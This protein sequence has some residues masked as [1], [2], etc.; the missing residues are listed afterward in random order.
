MWFL[1][2]WSTATLINLFSSLIK[3]TSLEGS[4]M[5]VL[6]LQVQSF[7]F[8]LWVFCSLKK[9]NSSFPCLK[10]LVLILLDFSKSVSFYYMVII[11][12]LCSTISWPRIIQIFS[13]TSRS[14]AYFIGF[15]WPFLIFAI[16][17]I[18]GFYLTRN[19]YNIV[20]IWPLEL[21]QHY[22]SRI[23]C[24]NQQ[25]WPMHDSMNVS[26]TK[27]DVWDFWSWCM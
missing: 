4:Q 2:K 10:N 14:K 26:H 27:F 3:T 21:S 25:L 24:K 18:S 22:E 19:N 8:L 16:F 13:K 5:F 23:H 11:Q 20:I 12:D 7:I 17:L 1:C 6:K 9:Y 15:L